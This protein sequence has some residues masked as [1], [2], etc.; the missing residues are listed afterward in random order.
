M[1]IVLN[2]LFEEARNG[3]IFLDEVGELTK[4]T[5]AKLSHV[6][7]EKSIIRVGGTKSIPVDVRIIAASSLNLEKAMREGTFREDFYYQLNECQ[8]I[9]L[10]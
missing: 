3:T 6:L 1:V 7:R 9:Y 8:F 10:P 5:Q 2:G 4:K